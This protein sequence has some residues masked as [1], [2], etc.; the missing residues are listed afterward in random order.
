MRQVR[1]PDLVRHLVRDETR[2]AGRLRLE[3]DEGESLPQ[4]RKQEQIRGAVEHID[5]IVRLNKAHPRFQSI[6][7]D[8]SAQLR[9]GM[10]QAGKQQHA[11]RQ[12]F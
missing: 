2:Q 7:P 4:R 1:D 3:K 6:L 12:E 10:I 11:L 9:I 8:R 5:G